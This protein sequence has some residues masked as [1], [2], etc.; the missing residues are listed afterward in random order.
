MA[1]GRERA[2]WS[3]WRPLLSFLTGEDLSPPK[4]RVARQPLPGGHH[5]PGGFRPRSADQLAAWLGER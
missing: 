3:R 5:K 2:E 1:D 4:F